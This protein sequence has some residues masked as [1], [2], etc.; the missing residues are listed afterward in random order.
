[1][2]TVS[3]EQMDKSFLDEYNSQ[4]AILKYSTQTAGHGVNYLIRHD[5]ARVYDDAID[6]CRRTSSAPLRFLEFGCGAGMNLMGLLARLESR[7]IAV[8]EAYGTDFSAALI[9]SARREAQAFIP[10]KD[11]EKVRFHVARNERLSLDLAAASG[12]TVETLHGSFDFIFGVNTF[13]YCHRLQKADDCASDIFRLLRPGGVCVMIDMNDRFPL[14]RSHLKG[15]VESPEE[16]YLPSLEEYA[17]PFTR[18][19]FELT[20]KDHFCW[21]PHSAGPALT[22]ACRALTPVL[23]ATAR[24]RAMRSLVVAQKRV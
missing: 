1:M 13:R 15:S 8:E 14:F 23:N 4:D 16:A 2:P 10:A 17:A 3:T 18:A 9:E 5:Y 22:A 6:A 20:R 24:S 7:G 11:R 12:R 19:G 21:V